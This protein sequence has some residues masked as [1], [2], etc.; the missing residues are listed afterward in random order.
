ML[1]WL[2]SRTFFGVIASIIAHHKGRGEVAW[3]LLGFVFHLLALIVFALPPACR[4]GITKK[5]PECGEVVKSEAKVCRYCS[6]EFLA[7][8]T[9]EVS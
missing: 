4:A 8:D 3:F 6:R 2:V 5:C 9:A 7:V 1:L